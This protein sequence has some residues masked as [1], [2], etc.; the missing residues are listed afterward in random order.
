MTY[1]SKISQA[2]NDAELKP[3]VDNRA[4][5]VLESSSETSK[6]DGE[7]NPVAHVRKALLNYD[8][9]II[10]TRN[11]IDINNAK[12]ER[13]KGASKRYSKKYFD[14]VVLDR[15]LQTYLEKLIEGK[16][17]AYKRIQNILS[18]YYPRNAKIWLLYFI[19]KKTLDDISYE[20]Q[21]GV[22]QLK[23]IIAKMRLDL[24]KYNL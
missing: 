18:I 3:D 1:R 4:E 10:A 19:S 11:E 14:A 24:I 6:D 12:L 21:I 7:N 20:M 17:H 15:K 2:E 8:L 16:N 5:M 23:K 9:E 22:F 13:Y